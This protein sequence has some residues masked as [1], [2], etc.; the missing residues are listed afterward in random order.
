MRTTTCSAFVL[1]IALLATVPVTICAATPE[2]AVLRSFFSRNVPGWRLDT[3][4]TPAIGVVTRPIRLRPR[5]LLLPE[6]AEPRFRIVRDAAR[7]HD[8]TYKDP[9]GADQLRP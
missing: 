1:S 7:A 2:Q 9:G 5:P 6:T 8:S 4:E 3:S